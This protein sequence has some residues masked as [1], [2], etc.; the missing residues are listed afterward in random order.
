MVAVSVA[1][2]FSVESASGGTKGI[3]GLVMIALVWQGVRVNL[4]LFFAAIQAFAVSPETTGPE[5]TTLIIGSAFV[6]AVWVLS[7]IVIAIFDGV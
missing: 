1:T 7:L 4:L 5:S 2:A 6:C 3:E